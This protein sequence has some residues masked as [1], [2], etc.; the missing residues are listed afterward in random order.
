MRD[1]DPV[2]A[3]MDAVRSPFDDAELYDVFFSNFDFDRS[4]Y[5]ELARSAGGP[6]LEVACGTGRILIPCL[7]AGV[8]IDGLDV[9]QPMLEQLRRKASALGIN[10]RVY[11][12][13]MR[14]FTLPRRYALVFISFNGFVHCLTTRD[15]LVTLQACRDHLR[16][17]GLLAFNIFYPGIE[18]LTG[19]QGIPVLEGEVAH[20]VSGLPVRMY[21]TRTLNHIEQIQHSRVEV[22]ELDAQGSVTASHRSETDM[23]WTFL[24][25]MELLLRVAGFKSWKIYGGFDR[26]PLAAANDEM[27]VFAWRD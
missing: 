1:D 3:A 7:Q 13:D 8:D 18:Y 21:D 2:A 14:G 26:R 20:P 10:P 16:P 22:Q 11:S 19:P 23:R 5:L 6:V 12:G 9:S 4:F 25:E 17:G 27:V 15:Q 24:P